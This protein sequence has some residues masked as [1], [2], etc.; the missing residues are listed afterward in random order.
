MEGHGDLNLHDLKI[1][2][3]CLQVYDFRTGSVSSDSGY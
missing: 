2:A 3:N 1:I